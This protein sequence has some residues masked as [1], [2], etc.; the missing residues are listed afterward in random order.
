M[1]AERPGSIPTLERRNG[2]KIDLPLLLLTYSLPPEFA[3]TEFADYPRL[4]TFP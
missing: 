1:D 3:Q 4:R 2:Q